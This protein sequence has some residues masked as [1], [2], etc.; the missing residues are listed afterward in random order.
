[1]ARWQINLAVL[2]LGN[3][4]V[5]M[6]AT[7]VVPFLPLYIQELGI[8]DSHELSVWTG[9]IF[10]GNFATS[11]IFQPIWGSLADRYG[12]KF[13]LLR[14]GFGMAIV[15]SL[16]GFVTEPWHL[17]ALRLLNGVVFGFNPAA[18][19]LIAATAPKERVGFALGT[20]QSGMVAGTFLGPLIGGLLQEWI[21]FR[22]I[23]WLTGGLMVLASLLAMITVKDPFNAKAA[24]AQPQTTIYQGLL[25]LW[26]I[27]QLPALF[28][29]T[30]LIQFAM[31]CSLPQIPIFVQELYK[32]GPFLAFIVGLVSSVM[33]IS[34]MIAAP[35]LGR[36][37]DRLG[38]ER[39]LL[40]T[41]IG[42]GLLFIPQALV[43]DVWQLLIVRFVLG[44]F[45]GGLLPSVSTL[46]KHYTPEGM[47]SRAFSLNSSSL[48]FGNMLG[49]IVGGFLS[50]WISI[51][52]LFL[53]ATVLFL[54]NAAWVS[55]TMFIKAPDKSNKPMPE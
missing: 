1:M 49:P 12:R 39:V 17:L 23:F 46:I 30:M 22:P 28:T 55:V 33:G 34:N 6:G 31:L 36:L 14:S 37:G 15:I 40:F 38:P 25:K 20:L 45:M 50:G 42:T 3:F 7:M 35:L 41:L 43:T 27:P 13:M 24:A 9:F 18:A 44:L 19:S 32:N 48:S 16:M 52:G 54:G 26:R 29:V 4:L 47:E 53:L 11:F 5:M 21:G 10:A 51:R 2:W 8:T